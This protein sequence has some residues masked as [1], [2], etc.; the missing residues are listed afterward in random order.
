MRKFGAFLYDF[1]V[2]DDWRI[3]VAV[4]LVGG[5]GGGRADPPGQPDDRGPPT[6]TEQPGRGHHQRVEA[7]RTGRELLQQAGAHPRFPEPV[8]VPRHR[9]RA[10]PIR[11]AVEL[12]RDVV[13]HPGLG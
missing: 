5:T 7:A 6:L 10:Q 12:D 4:V 9:F 2:G 1:V 8:D 11:Q 3:A 13:G